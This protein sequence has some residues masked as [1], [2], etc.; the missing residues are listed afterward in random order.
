MF[1][2]FFRSGTLLCQDRRRLIIIG[3]R[4]DETGSFTWP[5]LPN[6]DM[7]WG[8][9]Y[10]A[11]FD[12]D[13]SL[14]LTAKQEQAV[15][16]APWRIRKFPDPAM[17]KIPVAEP[18]FPTRTLVS[19]YRTSFPMHA[20]FVRLADGG[21]RFFHVREVAAC[22]GF[23]PTFRLD[24]L[25]ANNHNRLYAQLGNAV[26][27]PLVALVAVPLLAMLGIQC[28][29]PDIAENMAREAVMYE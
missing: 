25:P 12:E 1:L 27:P 11:R 5:E 16:Q 29:E 23:P 22:M 19:S 9:A 26:P 13:P 15:L 2:I 21:Y 28:D 17:R 18:Q 10:R 24:A 7:K 4:L 3:Q 20:Q 14:R 8:Q 6:L